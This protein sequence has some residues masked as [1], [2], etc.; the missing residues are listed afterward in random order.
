MYMHKF[1]K[2]LI[3]LSERLVVRN[4]MIQVLICRLADKA[5]MERKFML[6]TESLEVNLIKITTMRF[7]G[8]SKAESRLN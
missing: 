3:L 8:V 7:H 4:Q 1:Y 5:Q 6:L 2:F